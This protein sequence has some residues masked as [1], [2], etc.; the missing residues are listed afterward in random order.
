MGQTANIMLRMWR[1]WGIVLLVTVGSIGC[2]SDGLEEP[3]DLILPF[4]TVFE[5]VS[6][7]VETEALQPEE[8]PNLQAPTRLRTRVHATNRNDTRTVIGVAPCALQVQIFDNEDRSGTPIWDSHVFNGTCTEDGY[9]IGLDPEQSRVFGVITSAIDVLGD[10][11]D[12]ALYYILARLR[13]D[14][15]VIEM[16]A[17]ALRLT[18]G[19]EGLTYEVNTEVVEGSQRLLRSWLRI[20]N[21]NNHPVSAEYRDCPLQ[22]LAYAPD[23]TTGVFAWRS[24][25]QLDPDTGQEKVCT[26]TLQRTI[27]PGNDSFLFEY[28]MPVDAILTSGLAEGTYDFRSTMRLNWRTLR[29]QAG[30]ASISQ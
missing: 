15:H 11:F 7:E 18:Y 17:G 30:T 20:K 16:D 22:L 24:D 6:Y 3:D 8:P 28:L 4:R 19:L 23:D 13:I 9:Q 21:N 25:T 26:S 2:S 5:G 10:Q 12:P 1:L 29:F 27:I 14:E